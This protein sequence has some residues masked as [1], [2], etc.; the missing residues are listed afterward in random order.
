MASLFPGFA[1]KG[2]LIYLNDK[3]GNLSY[4]IIAVEK[5][6][7]RGELHNRLASLYN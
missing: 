1:K 5:K 7:D 4:N 3:L 2:L 6:S